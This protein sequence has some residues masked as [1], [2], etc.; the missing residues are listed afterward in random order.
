MPRVRS[1]VEN[2][3]SLAEDE[4]A[5]NSTGASSWRNEDSSEKS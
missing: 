5:F 1:R 2:D 3:M 4:E